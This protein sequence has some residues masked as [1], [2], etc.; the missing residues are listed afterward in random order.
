MGNKTPSNQRS[1]PRVEES[2]PITEVN[3]NEVKVAD[4]NRLAEIKTKWRKLKEGMT[5]ST[6]TKISIIKQALPGLQILYEPLK[7]YYSLDK[8]IM[9]SNFGAISHA[10]CRKDLENEVMVKVINLENVT[11]HLL[12]LIQELVVQTKVNHPNIAKVNSILSEGD[13]IYLIFDYSKYMCLWDYVIDRQKI[14]EIDTVKIISQLL[15]IVSYLNSKNICHRDL[16]PETI[17]IDTSTLNIKLV[18]FEFSAFLIESQTLK[19]KIGSV[20]YMAPEVIKRSYGKECDIWSIGAIAFFLLTG[21]PPFLADKLVNVPDKIESFQLNFVNED[22]EDRSMESMAFIRKALTIEVNNRL[23]L[24]DAL[25]HPWITHD[26][27]KIISIDDKKK[28]Y[29]LDDETFDIFL[30][31]IFIIWWEYF[32]IDSLKWLI[33]LYDSS[34]NK[35]AFQIFINDM[36]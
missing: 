33:S 17:L 5:L 34:L 14:S 18:N 29:K 32:N 8:V 15:D 25:D 27:T 13:K 35:K 6:G 4:N 22:W 12:F 10:Y 7:T 1:L 28:E 16:R 31:E 36:K 11:S 26:S 21:F 3:L 20:Y 2:M 24:S 9:S 19:T 23:K 30:K